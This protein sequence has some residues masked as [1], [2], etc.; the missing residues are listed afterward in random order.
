MTGI[1]RRAFL[2]AGGITLA[3]AAAGWGSLSAAAGTVPEASVA[4]SIARRPF[5]S[6]ASVVRNAP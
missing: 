6:G 3:T 1:G 5:A 2:G 4:Q